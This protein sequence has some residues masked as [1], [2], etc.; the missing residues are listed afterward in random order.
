MGKYIFIKGIFDTTDLFSNEII[1]ELEKNGD[2]CLCINISHLERDLKVLFNSINEEPADSVIAFNNLGYNLGE[3]EGGNIW[4]RYNIPYI[5]ILMDHPFHFSDKIPKLP[6]TT[7]LFCIDKKHVSF[8]GKY[9]KGVEVEFLPHAGCKNAID[10]LPDAKKRDIDILYAGNLSRVLVERLIPD[11][12]RYP[13]IDGAK[14]SKE[15]LN[16]LITNPKLTTEEVISDLL[17]KEGLC[18][19]LKEELNYISGFRF[20]DGFAVSYFREL[21]V[22]IL[23][24]N[25][26]HVSILGLGWETCEWADNN[27]LTIIGK[28]DASEVLSYMKRSKIVLNTLTWFK[29]G[30]HDRIFNGA[31]SKAAVLTDSSEYLHDQFNDNEISFFELEDITKLPYITDRILSDK[32]LRE[33]MIEASYS[34]ICKNHTWTNRLSIIK[35]KL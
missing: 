20:I 22:R 1:S 9:Y 34:K 28:V 19:S 10:I 16:N 14:I 31:L 30:S 3:E 27:N 18:L 32:E 15:A 26:F 8:V 4:E 2:E 24:E 25:G 33:K 12:D 17:Y 23:V 7:K 13:E 29:D 6:F 35:E 5:D 11:F 21:A